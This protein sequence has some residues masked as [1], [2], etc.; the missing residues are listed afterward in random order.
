MAGSGWRTKGTAL[1]CYVVAQAGSAVLVIWVFYQG[2]GY[3]LAPAPLP[4]PWPFLIDMSLLLLFGLQ[5]SGMARAGFKQRWTQVIP[6]PLERS[7]YAAT[8]GLVVL[9][10][11]LLW[12]SLGATVLWRL[13]V[14]L[15]VVPLLASVGVV[16]LNLGFDHAG[17]LGLRQAWAGTA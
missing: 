5:H 8:S 10:V 1:L 13:P 9:A 4:L 12:Q 7:L 11:V 2:L 15:I 17:L 3:T 6:A 16:L 14:W